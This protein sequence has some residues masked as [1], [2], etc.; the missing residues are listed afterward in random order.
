MLKPPTGSASLQVAEEI[1]TITNNAITQI[2]S[3]HQ[4]SPGATTAQIE[5]ALG[6][7]N[8]SVLKTLQLAAAQADP[9]KHAAAQAALA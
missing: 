9:A 2:A 8:T 5:E 6:E 4:G 7:P 1:V 3:L